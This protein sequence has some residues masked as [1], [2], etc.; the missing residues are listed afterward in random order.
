MSLKYDATLKLLIVGDSGTGKTCV[1]IAYTQDVFDDDMRSTIGADVKVQIVH[2]RNQRIKLRIWDTAGQERFRQLT[3]AFYR[4]AEGVVVVYDVTNRRSFENVNEWLKEAEVFSTCP[5]VLCL[6]GNKTDIERRR[7]IT[8]DEGADFAKQRGILFFETSAK[9]RVGIV[10]M[11]EGLVERIF[12]TPDVYKHV[13]TSVHPRNEVRIDLPRE[14]SSCCYSGEPRTE[15]PWEIMEEP[16]LQHPSHADYQKQHSPSLV[17][18]G[19]DNLKIESNALS[20]SSCLGAD[21]IVNAGSKSNHGSSIWTIESHFSINIEQQPVEVDD[22][23][24][25]IEDIALKIKE[26]ILKMYDENSST[27]SGYKRRSG[28]FISYKQSDGFDALAERLYRDLEGDN[29]LDRYYDG[30]RTK[31]SMIKGILRRD[32]CVICISPRYFLSEWCNTELTVALRGKK[33]IVPVFN[34][35]NFT[36]GDMLKCIPACFAELKNHDFIGLFLDTIP[37]RGQIMKVRN[38][39]IDKGGGIWEDSEEEERFCLCCGDC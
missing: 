5:H 31:Q 36:A 38:A 15:E 6:V 7:K 2:Q 32:K 28:W 33:I 19:S 1:L 21:K 18:L 29:W 25:K 26:E 22:L 11:F 39:G 13:T 27:F 23:Q 8:R 20:N 14:R 30:T 17:S 12:D 35:D 9:T 34:Q 37:C 24:R 10:E 4:D 3:S 16:L